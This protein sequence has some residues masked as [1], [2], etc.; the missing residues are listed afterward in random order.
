M[1]MIKKE[2]TRILSMDLAEMDKWYWKMFNILNHNF[3]HLKIHGKKQVTDLIDTLE[4]KWENLI[5]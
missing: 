3:K 4:I 1:K 2:I 5:K